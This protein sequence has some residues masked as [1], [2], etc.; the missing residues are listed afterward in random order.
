[1]AQPTFETLHVYQLAERLANEVWNVVIQWSTF[2]QDTVGK[3]F[4]RAADSVGS[5]LAEGYGRGSYADSKRFVLIS[6]GS[7][8]ETI[9]CLRRASTRN[10]ITPEQS[11]CLFT[12]TDELGPRLN[13]Y[14]NFIIKQ[15]KNHEIRGET[16]T[17]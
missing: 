14:L 13:A 2:A 15:L 10:L 5:N 11:K 9:C 7:L 17:G 4:V 6:R 3:Q 8:N 12:I 1:M 16:P